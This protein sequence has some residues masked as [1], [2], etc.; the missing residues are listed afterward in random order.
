M[1]A[2][3][4]LS[5]WTRVLQNRNP[6]YEV[7]YQGNSYWAVRWH[8]LKNRKKLVRLEVRY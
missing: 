6:M 1:N 2:K 5:V 4:T 3:Y 8:L 7:V